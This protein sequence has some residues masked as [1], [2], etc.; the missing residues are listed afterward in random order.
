M[1]RRRFDLYETN[2]KQTEAIRLH[3]DRW[4]DEGETIL[5]PCV[6]NGAMLRVLEEA[7]PLCRIVTNDINPDVQVSPDYQLDMTLPESWDRILEETRGIDWV[8]TNVPFNRA[9]AI[10]PLALKSVRWGVYTILPLN[11]LEPTGGR[12][13]WLQE[14]PL[15]LLWTFGQPRPS[16]TD[17][18][19]HFITTAWMGWDKREV[20]R[21]PDRGTDVRFLTNWTD[22]SVPDNW[23]METWR[24][25]TEE[26]TEEA[27]NP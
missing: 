19:T 22:L 6:G 17:K 25:M 5:E 9:E 4:I 26:G 14:N 13:D 11:Y 23:Q 7:Y 24:W 18:G 2:R 1:P 21:D 27:L 10:L 8:I 15:S 3:L 12:G 16:Y 20:W